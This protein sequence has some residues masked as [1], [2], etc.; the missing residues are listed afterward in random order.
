MFSFIQNTIYVRIKPDLMSVLHI[1]SENE[2]NDIPIIAIES[3]G[4]K[5][6][7]TAIGLETSKLSGNTN[8]HVT[9]GFKHPRTLLADFAKAERTLKYFVA[10][11]RPISFFIP[12][13]VLIIHPQEVLEGGLT[14]LEIRAF[15]ELGAMLGA[16]HVYVWEGAS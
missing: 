14:Q 3:K 9:N 12:A 15:R 13:P 10:K 4:G 6:S 5:N 16:R 11:V 1:Q 8:I 2:Y 7:I